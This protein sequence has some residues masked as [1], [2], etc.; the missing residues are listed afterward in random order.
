MTYASLEQRMAHTYLDT[1]APFVPDDNGIKSGIT[2]AE[3]EAFYG[4]MHNLYRL[5]FEEPSLFVRQL[6]EDDAFPNRFHKSSYGKPGLQAN[7]RKFTKEMDALLENMFLIGR[8][9]S[10]VKLSKRQQAVLTRLGIGDMQSLPPMW[11]W[12]SARPGS[13][14]L[15]FAHCF[16][17]EDYPYTSEFFARAL[18]DAPAFRKLESWMIGRG[19]R[20]HDFLHVTASDCRIS[21]TYAN[22]AW[23]EETPRGGFEYKIRHTG[24]SA[25]Y[26]REAANPPVFGLCIP[27]GMKDCLTAFGLMDESLQGFVL[28]RTK[29][30]DGC[31]YCV[32]TDKSGSRP[33]AY[34]PITHEQS[35]YALC[36][37]F[38][39]YSYCWPGIN[40]DL[41][42][43]LIAMLAFMDDH[44]PTER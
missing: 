17:K 26:D 14:S 28:S 41:A 10:A 16:F 6:H 25:R 12:L 21:M 1:L 37:Y 33:L 30:C 40:D 29:R 9:P 23:S 39:G 35:S 13:T 3:Q 22:P 36:P 15:A 8:D 4:L 11:K 38:P 44:L 7:M 20:R 32:Q 43:R 18:G 5:A 24:I 42:D 34:I 31:R 19:Y 2:A 27:G